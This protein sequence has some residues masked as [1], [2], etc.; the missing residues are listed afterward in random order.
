VS[1]IISSAY[2]L[3]IIKIIS[4]YLLKNLGE[5]ISNH[6]Q[7]S[8]EMEGS[9]KILPGVRDLSLEQVE[10]GLSGKP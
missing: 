10:A 4:Q 5:V 7:N 2:Y 8:G 9:V 1:I 6:I 3:F